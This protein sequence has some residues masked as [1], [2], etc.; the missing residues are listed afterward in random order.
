MSLI[1]SM[2]VGQVWFVCGCI[3]TSSLLSQPSPNL[4]VYFTQ[5]VQW[6]RIHTFLVVRLVIYSQGCT[7]YRYRCI[8]G[9]L[10]EVHGGLQSGVTAMCTHPW[11]PHQRGV[12]SIFYPL[13]LA[14]VG[15]SVDWHIN[16]ERSTRLLSTKT[17]EV[18][19]YLDLA[20]GYWGGAL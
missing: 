15:L 6:N 16:N 13:Y 4:S 1:N 11:Q 7:L 14:N 17:V 2:L 10:P 9:S 18:D 3:F 5:A 19:T 20:S 8:A 12:T